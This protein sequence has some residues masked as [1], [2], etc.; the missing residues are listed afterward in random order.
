MPWFYS[1]GFGL[2]CTALFV[3]LN[4]QFGGGFTFF[5]GNIAPNS[6]LFEGKRVASLHFLRGKSVVSLHFLRG[7]CVL[8]GL[9]LIVATALYRSAPCNSSLKSA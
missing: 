3:E 8:A 7:K 9:V 4:G 5:E 6:T 2:F 1:I